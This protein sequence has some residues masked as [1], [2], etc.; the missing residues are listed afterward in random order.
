L[1]QATINAF[2]EIAS[3]LQE[4]QYAGSLAHELR[5]NE[6]KRKKKKRLHHL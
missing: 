4:D 6:R 1:S 3:A 5:E 2:K